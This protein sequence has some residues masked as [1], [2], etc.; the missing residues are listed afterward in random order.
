MVAHKSIID[1]ADDLRKP[2]N[3]TNEP[4]QRLVG[5]ICLSLR[6][7]A[8]ICSKLAREHYDQRLG[9]RSLKV[10]VA[11]IEEAVLEA[12]LEEEKEIEED[13]DL[14][15]FAIDLH[16]DEIRCMAAGQIS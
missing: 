7:D 13:A 16:N 12:Y 1:L 8:S 15:D 4:K 10:G 11:S 2:I 3:L 14:V 9:A 5:N 6:D